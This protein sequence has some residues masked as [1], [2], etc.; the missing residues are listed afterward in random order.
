[1]ESGSLE[2][3]LSKLQTIVLTSEVM[4]LKNFSSSHSHGTLSFEFNR[5][6]ARKPKWHREDV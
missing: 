4:K 1:M 3:T 2:R 5:Y 6:T